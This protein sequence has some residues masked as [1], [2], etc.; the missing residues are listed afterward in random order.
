MRLTAARV[1]T[2]ANLATSRDDLVPFALLRG[3]REYVMGGRS[4]RATVGG[5][6]SCSPNGRGSFYGPKLRSSWPSGAWLWSRFSCLQWPVHWRGRQFSAAAVIGNWRVCHTGDRDSLVNRIEESERDK[7]V[8]KWVALLIH[9]RAP[10]VQRHAPADNLEE[11][12]RGIV[13]RRPGTTLKQRFLRSASGI[14]TPTIPA[15]LLNI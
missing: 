9:L 6:G 4:G 7:W 13:G 3:I 10:I 8:R 12:L 2:W 14:L 11:F 1:H 5:G 15:T